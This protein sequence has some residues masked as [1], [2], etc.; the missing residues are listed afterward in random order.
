MK[1]VLEALKKLGNGDNEQKILH[2]QF[3]YFISKKGM[4][5]LL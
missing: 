4:Y 1:A 3:S 2:E 5:F